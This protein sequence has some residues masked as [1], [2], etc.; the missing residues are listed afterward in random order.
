M[1]LYDVLNNIEI[2]ATLSHL[3][4]GERTLFKEQ[5]KYLKK[6]DL[7]IFDRGFPS[8]ELYGILNR[9]KIDFVMRLRKTDFPKEFAELVENSALKEKIITAEMKR[10]D[11][12]KDKNIAKSITLRLVKVV[13][14]S[15]EI[16]ILATS[17][18]DENIFKAE[19]FKDIYWLRWGVETYF[20]I[21]KNRL[22]L[23][24][25]TGKSVESIYQ[26]FFVTIFI[27]N[28][29]TALVK[30]TNLKLEERSKSNKNK[31]KVNHSVSFNEIKNRIFEIFYSSNKNEIEIQ[32]DLE[33]IFLLSPSQERIRKKVER[34]KTK[35]YK[36]LSY[37]KYTKK[38][39]F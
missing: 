12:I 27:S 20:D 31:Q 38:S 25:F 34:K 1:V 35:I 9:E 36:S 18:I 6:G 32:E 28:L 8:Y 37:Q 2:N 17:I 22:D 39:V 21:V 13:L 30:D 14:D 7:A 26:D 5:I 33:K 23:G 15:G 3:D 29:E 11:K 4:K 24:N 10:P 19:E 16:E